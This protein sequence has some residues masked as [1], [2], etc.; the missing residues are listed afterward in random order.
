MFNRSWRATQLQGSGLLGRAAVALP[1]LLAATQL[2]AAPVVST[3]S[4]GPSALN[5][6]YFGYVDG[7]TASVVQFHTPVGLAF[8]ST[9]D[10]LFVADRDNNAVRAL[11][12]QGNLT[13]TFTTNRISKPVG[14]VLD[15][16]DN[17]Y[18]LNRGNGRNGTILEFDYYGD[19]VATNASGLTNVNAIAMDPTGS[20]YVTGGTKT[21]TVMQISP[22]GLLTTIV[23]VT[24]SGASLQGLTVMDNGWLAVCDA[25]RNGI[26]LVDPITG[27]ISNLTGFNGVG[28]YTGVNN[29]GATK[30]TAQFF[31]PYGL[32]K[33]GN[34]ML[35]VADFGNNRVKVINPVGTVTNLYG[36]HSNLWY[37]G[38]GAYPGWYDGTVVVPDVLGDVESR[39]P[40]GVVVAPDGTVYVTEDYYHLIRHVTGAGLAGPGAL[41]TPPLF[42]NPRGV[43]LNSASSRL[44]IADQGNNAIQSLNLGNNQTTEFLGAAQGVSAP[45][46][47]VVDAGD[48]LYV[49][50]QGPAG[51]GSI[52]KYDPYG[53]LLLTNVT[54]L[55]APTSFTID[56]SGNLYVAEQNGVVQRFK[57]T[58]ANG[59]AVATNTV[60]TV[61]NAGASIQGIALFDDGTIALS[62]AGNHVLWQVNP[63]SKAV[64]VLSGSPG[65]PGAA[66]GL[67]GVARLN[68][69]HQLARAAGDLLLTADYGNNR[70]VIVDRFGSITNVLNS[71]NA[72]VWYGAAD[73]P[74]AST[75]AHPIKMVA[76]VGVAL[77]AGGVAYSSESSYDIIRGISG[78]GLAEPGIGGGGGTGTNVVILPPTFSPNSGY[79]PMGQLITVSSPNP[80]VYYTTDGTEPTTNSLPVLMSGNVGTLLWRSSLND[81]T[82]LRLKA[83]VSTNASVSVA[84]VAAPTNSIGITPAATASGEIFAGI[85]SRIVV[86]VVANLQANAQIKSYQFRVEVTPNGGALPVTEFETLPV[87]ANDFVPLV[88]A[89]QGNTTLNLAGEPYALGNTRGLA[90]STANNGS[91]AFQKFAVVAL[92]KV[93][94]PYS[95]IEGDSY[96]I[97]VSYPSATAD[98]LNQ[99]VP[100]LTQSA[101]SI[102]VTNVPYTV[103]DSASSSGAWYSA[104]NFGNRDLDNADVNNAFN[105]ALGIKVPFAFSD[106]FNAMDAYPPD[107]ASFTGGDGQIRF[108]DWQII[109]QR[110][111]RLNTNN[112]ERA[113][114]AGGN[115][116]NVAATLTVGGVQ[117]L[118]RPLA[119]PAG[120]WYRQALVGANS[121]GYATPG[122]DVSVPVYAKLANGASLSGL[123]F[124]VLVTPQND[125]PALA[126]APQLTVAAAVP[127]PAYQQSPQLG[128]Q[129]FGWPLGALTNFV[130]R[131]SNFVGLVS[132]TI[133]PSAQSGQRYTVSFANVDGAP[134]FNTQYDFETRSAEVAVNVAA[135][136]A[137]VCSD[138]W[139]RHYFGSLDDA[140]G[141]DLAD[142]DGDGVPNWMEY[143]AGTDPL[144]TA[145]KLMV[146]GIGSQRAQG[147]AQTLVQWQ[148][149]PGKAYSV[150]WSTSLSSPVW[151]PLGTVAGDGGTVSCL[152]TNAAG[153]VRYY[154]LQ[155]L[156]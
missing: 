17:V 136:P 52:R 63:V 3:T 42:R 55:A 50:N 62:D 132:F 133:P 4:G 150:Q 152:D 36:V 96:S 47:V 128:Q 54:G 110:A 46:D 123:Q 118:A 148:S 53:N 65:H 115:L 93:T 72:S 74:H 134:D 58:A 61:T 83:F 145:S 41:G 81:L 18:V 67:A 112:W 30:T 124:R 34:G 24:N 151:Y 84:G 126:G 21:N 143:Q 142:P 138:D 77:G 29:R 120:A 51:N 139:K 80:N 99:A 106:V 117:A 131:S 48:Y 100:L 140:S 86:P 82:S 107:T 121:V 130:S 147:Q 15:S 19:L 116:V 119:L 95:A 102:L 111:L 92:L 153:T 87:T 25:G 31:A 7:D 20:L 40:N 109:L 98:G 23:T 8:D 108:L 70:L 2:L 69:P 129:A 71:T 154:R 114:S 155:L 105:A 6:S 1:A 13:F 90:I 35:V 5:P 45:V 113:W 88:T 104:G 127:R 32:A 49:L 137:A 43:A 57:S 125:A 56:G 101:A 78:T 97:A 146:G 89:A 38:T 73:D 44:F 14:V 66:L 156:P 9:G 33:A 22:A 79:Y 11:D 16:M 94:I 144:D 28:D 64:T 75:A 39:S 141:S 59:P 149:A 76:P 68:Q 135:V 10:Y 122:S 60:V 12:L 26:L 37:T 27:S 103:G 91:F 85:G